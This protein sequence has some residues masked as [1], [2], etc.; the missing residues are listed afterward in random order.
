MSRRFTS[1][2]A[3]HA[4]VHLPPLQI[5]AHHLDAHLVA[6]PVAALATPADQAVRRL[7]EVIVVI[8]QGA[9]VD[10]ALDRELLRLREE[11]VLRAR[12]GKLLVP[13]DFTELPSV[14]GPGGWLTPSGELVALGA[15]MGELKVLRG[16]NS[17]P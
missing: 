4:E 16:F 10:A 13:E 8:D 14:E 1:S 11:A 2:F 7:V 3:R 12:Q 15:T 6:Q 17:E 5:D 9:D